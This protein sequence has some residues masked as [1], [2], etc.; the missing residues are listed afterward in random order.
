MSSIINFDG[1]KKDKLDHLGRS[2]FSQKQ[3]F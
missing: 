2:E 3:P 1:I